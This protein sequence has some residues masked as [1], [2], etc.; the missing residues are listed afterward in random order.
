MV[1]Y[2]FYNDY[3]QASYNPLDPTPED[4]FTP[5][6][7]RITL[8]DLAISGASGAIAMT[9]L[10]VAPILQAP[11][12]L[13][14]AGAGSYCLFMQVASH[15]GRNAFRFALIFAVSLMAALISG[16]DGL[17]LWLKYSSQVSRV[18]LGVGIFG[19]ALSAVIL[20]SG[21]YNTSK[22]GARQ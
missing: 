19:I 18:L 8:S 4:G 10:R 17:T 5:F 2:D 22:Q 20:L 6:D 14:V 12:I 3:E 16:W 7:E 13:I 1:N 11:V 15:N 9:L 21:L